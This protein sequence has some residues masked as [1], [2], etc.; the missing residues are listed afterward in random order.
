MGRQLRFAALAKAGLDDKTIVIFTS[1][2]G[3]HLGEHDF[4]AKVS[5]HEESVLVPLIVRVPGKEP[6]VCNSFAELLDLYPTISNMCGLEVPERL[7]GEDLSP[8]F[9][10]P[11][12]EVRD[13]AFSANGRGFLLRNDRWAYIQYGE[14]G[15][16]GAELFDMHNDLLQYTNL[17]DNPK[18]ADVAAEFKQK[19]AAKL[20]ALRTNDLDQ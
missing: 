1:D 7:Q 15:S 17:V 3:Y 4:W 12:H 20:K 2:H 9:D 18:Y 14:D 13:T 8:V 19:T 5:L 11:S 6:A 16:K 10:D